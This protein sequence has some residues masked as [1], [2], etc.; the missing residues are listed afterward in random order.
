MS[1]N[2][3]TQLSYG[4]FIKEVHFKITYLDQ[5]RGCIPRIC[6]NK[7][8]LYN[9]SKVLIITKYWRTIEFANLNYW[10][11]IRVSKPQEKLKYYGKRFK[12]MSKRS[13]YLGS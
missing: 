10:P 7:I 2:Y 9:S 11:C 13:Q 6:S 5:Q 8:G 3:L 12:E 4:L 1:L